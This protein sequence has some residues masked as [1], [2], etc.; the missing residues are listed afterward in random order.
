MSAALT[1]SGAARQRVNA[2]AM[3]SIAA[4]FQL[5]ICVGGTPYVV[6][7][8]ASVISSRMASRAT[9]ALNSAAWFLRFVILD[10]FFHQAIHL[11]NR[12][13]FSRPALSIIQMRAN[14]IVLPHTIMNPERRN[15]GQAR[16]DAQR[17]QK[18]GTG[19]NKELF[20]DGQARRPEPC[21]SRKVGRRT[22]TLVVCN[23]KARKCA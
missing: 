11:N 1:C 7:S 13:E 9:L 6:D 3:F 12:S 14:G 16:E 2:V 17:L 18:E 22:K 15:N 21:S 23:L 8:S 10:H 19:S 4:R 20:K 5:P